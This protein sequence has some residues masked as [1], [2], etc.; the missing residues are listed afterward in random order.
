MYPS[1]YYIF[2]DWFGVEWEWAK[3]LWTFGLMVA[4]S[5]MAAAFTLSRELKRKEKQGHLKPVEEIITVGKP[6]SFGELLI[7]ALIGFIVGYKIIGLIVF[8]PVEVSPPDYLFSSQGNFPAGMVVA[9]I[10]VFLKWKE[11]NKQKLPQPEK[12]TV[13]I[14]PHDRVGDIVVIALVSGILGAKIFDG[15]EH[16]DTFISNPIAYILSPGGLAFYGGLIFA[17]IAVSYYGRSKKIKLKHLVDSIAPGLMLAYAIGRIGCQVA[18]DGDW[19]VYNSAYVSDA[20]GNVI[21]ASPEQYKQALERNESYLLRGVVKDT[22]TGRDT[23]VTNR[24]YPSLNTVPSRNF[25]APSFLPKW[26]VAYT[27]PKNVNND[28]IRIPGDNDEHRRVLPMPVFPT[29]FYETVICLLFF[30]LLWY[31]RKRIK[32][33]MMLFGIYLILNGIERFVV[34]HIRV[35]QMYNVLGMQLSQAEIIAIILMLLGVGICIYSKKS[36]DSERN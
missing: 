32:I 20:Y 35:N 14:W 19:G 8:R 25:K 4:L 12:R 36:Y 9:A 3:V 34:E 28:G 17:A 13:R 22:E 27:F 30:G 29:A 33:P 10:A 7:N 11:K 2:K 16:W 23:I 1:L 26:M 24:V 21:A 5:F 6:A 31:L 18:G 15:I